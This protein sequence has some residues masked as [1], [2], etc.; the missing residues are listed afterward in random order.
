[1][2]MV[3]Y[4]D[5]IQSISLTAGSADPSYPL[6]NLRNGHPRIPFRTIGGNAAQLTIVTSGSETALSLVITNAVGISIVS[7]IAD[8]YSWGEDATGVTM[9]AGE[10]A[11]GAAL[12]FVDDSSSEAPISQTIQNYD[13]DS[14][15]LFASFGGQ[16]FSRTIVITLTATNDDVLSLG[17]LVIGQS[18][19]FRD[20]EHSTYQ[21]TTV[22]KG[23]LVELN[24]G[25][26]YYKPLR[27]LRKPSGY[28]V[29][30]AVQDGSD[31]DGYST[32]QD[33]MSLVWLA[34]GRT[35]HVWHFSDRG[36]EDNMMA[37]IDAEPVAVM[38]GLTSK[39]V[40]LQFKERI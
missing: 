1:M 8:V 31:P 19:R 37:S 40:S 27:I 36:L 33:F 16:G 11:A 4:N 26:D 9:T 28:I 10:D 35:P 2:T 39:T 25:T 34:K 30:Y 7:V 29:M 5:T 15:I 13:G 18:L 21:S 22:D 17:N 6:T 38:H 14:G 12:T 20:F 24:D 32:Y 23:T 3:I